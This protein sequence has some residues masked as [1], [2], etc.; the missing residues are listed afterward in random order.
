MR[1]WVKALSVFFIISFV[2]PPLSLARSGCCSHHGGVCGCRCCD[3]TGLSSTCA[4]YYPEC[5]GGSTIQKKVYIQPTK[6]PTFWI[7]EVPTPKPTK[8][9]TRIPTLIPAI[10]ITE[11]T[12]ETASENSDLSWPGFMVLGG[13]GYWIYKSSFKKNQS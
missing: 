3:G 9:P 12:P 6:R 10:R 11:K 13:L 4:P 7:T 2:C 8:V 1:S 5:S